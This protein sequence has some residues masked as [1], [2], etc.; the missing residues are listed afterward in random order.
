MVTV[1]PGAG[2]GRVFASL[3]VAAIVEGGQTMNPST[4]ELIHAFENLPTDKIIILPNN[5]NIVLTARQ[6]AELTVK[7]VA[8]VPCRSVPQGL[9]AMMRLVPDGDFDSVVQEMSAAIDDVETGEITI[10]TRSVEIDDVEVQEGQ[11]IALHNGKLVLAASN[12]EEACL[13]LLEKAHA[14][15][16]ELITMF[17]GANISRAEVFR[18][19][20]RVR[21]NFPDQEVEV[22]E[23][24]QPH[25]Q[26]I[27][28]IE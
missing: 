7:K 1:A 21:Q 13:G 15:H 25:Y 10:A 11:I 14:A 12:L 26:F 2:I 17:Y 24:C 16:F 4:Q 23:G 20:D 19:A 27:I 18:I 5:K 3:G 6:A 22:Q 9:A 28:A 8:V